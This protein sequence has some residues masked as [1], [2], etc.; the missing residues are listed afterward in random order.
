[1]NL[2]EVHQGKNCIMCHDLPEAERLTAVLTKR[3]IKVLLM[4]DREEMRDLKFKDIGRKKRFQA[5]H[6]KN[7]DAKGASLKRKNFSYKL[8]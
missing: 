1:M 6:G 2:V 4:V 8:E 3:G 7:R 5:V